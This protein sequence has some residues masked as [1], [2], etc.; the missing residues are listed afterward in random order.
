MNRGS[1]RQLY[2]GADQRHPKPD[3]VDEAYGL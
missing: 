1:P 2:G 3:Y